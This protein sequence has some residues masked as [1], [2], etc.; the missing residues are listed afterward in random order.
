[1]KY[2]EGDENIFLGEPEPLNK[3]K[4]PAT[5][6]FSIYPNPVEDW[7]I[8]N[9]GTPVPTSVSIVLVNFAGQLHSTLMPPRDLE[10]G[11]H[12]HSFSTAQIDRGVY[13]VVMK[14]GSKVKAEKV[15]LE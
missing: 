1:M 7:L 15:I 12:R 11:R 2:R 13:F 10:T 4:P 14:Y 9:T 5:V 3:E 6:S 8:I